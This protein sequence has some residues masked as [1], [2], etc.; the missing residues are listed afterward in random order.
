MSELSHIHL[1]QQMLKILQ[2]TFASSSRF[3]VEK[4]IQHFL[5]YLQTQ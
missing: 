4:R 5:H 1:D 3:A 2:A